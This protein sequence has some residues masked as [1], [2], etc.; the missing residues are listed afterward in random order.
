MSKESVKS[1]YGC[2]LY[3]DRNGNICKPFSTKHC[4]QDHWNC[5]WFLGIGLPLGKEGKK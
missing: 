1:C 3:Y 2:T 5:P 4:N